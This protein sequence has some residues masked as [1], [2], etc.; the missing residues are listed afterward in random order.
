MV[1][2]DPQRKDAL[3]QIDIFFVYLQSSSN[4]KN[5]VTPTL[6]RINTLT[7]EPIPKKILNTRVGALPSF[8]IY[9][10]NKLKYRF[11]EIF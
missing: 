6:Y 3:F 5:A 2:K 8:D 11:N 7:T 4:A 1:K 9:P 10:M